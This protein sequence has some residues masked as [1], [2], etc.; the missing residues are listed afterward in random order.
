MVSSQP[1]ATD[2][3][4]WMR[5]AL[6]LAQ[7][8][9]GETS[10]NP[11]V[12]A[13]LVQDGREIGKGWHHQAGK[14]HA[15]IEALNDAKARGNS[16][17]GATL[18]V[19]LEPCSTHGRTPPCTAAILEAGISRIVVA[20]TD[21]NPRHGGRGLD[22]LRDAGLRVESGILAPASLRLNEGFNHWI[23]N[24]S[25]WVTL[26]AG[27]TL[28][29]KIATASGESKWITGPQSR[30]R[31]M[32]LRQIHDAILVGI[33]TVLADD[34]S[35][36]VRI[37]GRRVICRRRIVIDSH[38]RTPVTAQVVTDVFAA[39]TLIVVGETAPIDRIETLR[40]HVNV[41]RA[42]LKSGRIDLPWLLQRLGAENVTRLL[43]EGGGEV[44][45]SFMES[46]LAHRVSFFYA[47]IIL[48]GKQAIPS[49]G[50]RGATSLADGNR[51]TDIE[52]MKV[53]DDLLLEA[54]IS[55]RTATD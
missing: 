15:E 41:C 53:G 47:P 44:H 7:R 55:K 25:P 23:Q 34:P 33:G 18:Y 49:V 30:R 12:G 42:P 22:L 21:P 36:T 16:P 5:Q 1:A 35:L 32:K 43:V 27:M 26:K 11:M 2:D 46:D 24:R 8:A 9:S 31:V 10:P 50:G 19:T 52:M 37:P 4:S 14:P 54:R 39:K 28:D 48:G 51:L 29:G 3:A 40:T 38:A 20:A 17:K 13:V 6:Q 45:A